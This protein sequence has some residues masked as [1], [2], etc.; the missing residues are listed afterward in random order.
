MI[1]NL[2]LTGN[3]LMSCV[4]VMGQLL[5]LWYVFLLLHIPFLSYSVKSCI[6]L[7]NIPISLYWGVI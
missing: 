6:I 1:R 4:P 2:S 7:L 3:H 5:L